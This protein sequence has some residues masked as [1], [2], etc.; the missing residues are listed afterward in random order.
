VEPAAARI[1]ET[2]SQSGSDDGLASEKLL[3]LVYE[4]LRI[5]ARQWMGLERPGQTLQPTALVHEAYLRLVG[6]GTVG[7]WDSPGHFFAA[8]ARAMRRILVERARRKLAGRHGGGRTRIDLDVAQPVAG[9]EADP[10]TTLALDLAL[11]KLEALDPRK[12]RV[13]MLRYFAGLTVEQT[14]AATGLSE[15]TVKGDWHF[16]RAWLY[17]E[18]TRGES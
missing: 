1:L 8:A 16:A 5:I 3:P 10:E 7:H 12:A 11:Q 9:C 2:L 14:A 13:V 4:E 15:R 6:P 18:M 17:G